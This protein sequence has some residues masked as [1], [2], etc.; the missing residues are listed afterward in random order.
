[1]IDYATRRAKARLSKQ[2]QDQATRNMKRTPEG[3]AKLLERSRTLAVEEAKAKRWLEG[4]PE[5]QAAARARAESSAAATAEIQAR[6]GAER[7]AAA[8][9]DRRRIEAN[10][11]READ[12]ERELKERKTDNRVTG[13]EGEV[14]ELQRKQDGAAK[15]EQ[16]AAK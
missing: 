10:A 15:S 9:A 14:R 6:E 8:E 13:L 1:V 12:E 2:R 3:R 7:E 5:A 16:R 11:Q 4:N